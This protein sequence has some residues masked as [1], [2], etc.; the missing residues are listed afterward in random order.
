MTNNSTLKVEK[1]FSK[2]ADDNG[3]VDFKT[4]RKIMRELGVEGW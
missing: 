3:E 4:L 2:Y 1:I